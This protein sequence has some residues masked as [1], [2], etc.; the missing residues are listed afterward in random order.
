[1]KNDWKYRFTSVKISCVFAKDRKR[2]KS[3]S[4]ES[5]LNNRNTESTE[6]VSLSVLDWWIGSM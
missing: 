5:I 1:M 6:A 4:I 2:N 3:Y